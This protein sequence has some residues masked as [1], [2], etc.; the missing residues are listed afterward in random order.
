MIETL[1]FNILYIFF[2]YPDNFLL[3]FIAHLQI[4]TIYWNYRNKTA[5]QKNTLRCQSHIDYIA[6][7][8]TNETKQSSQPQFQQTVI[9]HL[10]RVKPLSTY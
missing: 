5:V 8:S 10:K 3:K 2:Q 4:S 9:L 7:P 1:L 6:E